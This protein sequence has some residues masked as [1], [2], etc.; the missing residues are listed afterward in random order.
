MVVEKRSA[1]V[2]WVSNPPPFRVHIA[3]MYLHH[4]LWTE[5]SH[6]WY[7]LTGNSSSLFCEWPIWPML[8]PCYNTDE[9]CG[10][11]ALTSQRSNW[12]ITSLAPFCQYGG[13]QDQGLFVLWKG[14]FPHFHPPTHRPTHPPTPPQCTSAIYVIV[15]PTNWHFCLVEANLAS[16]TVHLLRYAPLTWQSVVHVPFPSGRVFKL[17]HLMDTGH[18]RKLLCV[19]E[20]ESCPLKN[21]GI[22]RYN[23]LSMKPVFPY[24]TG[25]SNPPPFRYCIWRPWEARCYGLTLA[26]TS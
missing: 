24:L 6:L 7:I 17:V 15:V 9:R 5:S 16:V 25:V 19:P 8:Y 21:T 18:N 4:D 3:S 11:N 1:Y 26:W 14:L 12:G 13:R 23:P 10:Q 20:S 22:F 2:S